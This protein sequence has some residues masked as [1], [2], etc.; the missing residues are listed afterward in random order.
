[1]PPQVP[2]KSPGLPCEQCEFVNEPERVYCHNCGAKLDRSLLPKADEKKVEP[3]DKARKRIQKMT[4]PNSGGV[5][6]EIKTLFKVAFF[7]ALVA[8]AWLLLQKPD[9]VPELKKDTELRLI[10]SDMMEALSSPTPRAISFSEDDVNHYLQQ[11]LKPQD[12]MIPG[13]QLVHAY[14]QCV[15][16]VLRIFSEQS[17]FGYPLFSRID[18]K[19]DVKDGKFTPTIVGGAFGKISIDPQAMQYADYAFGTLWTSLQREHKQMD[20]MQRIVVGQGR[21]DLVTK[22]AAAAR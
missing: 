14:V 6:R 21:I 16:G 9:D 17:A 11:T 10:S 19:L 1:M 2:P 8:A 3:Q 18:Y 12:T 5:W 4:N 22:G 15:P 7:A 20:K 13:V